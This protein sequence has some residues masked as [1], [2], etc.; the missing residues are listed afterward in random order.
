MASD[1]DST[2]F[3]DTE[4]QS[5]S[6]RSPASET[7]Y[8]DAG[9]A[10]ASEEL[11]EHSA[12]VQS[13]LVSLEEKRKQLER[14]R[15]DVEEAKRRRAE[16]ATGFDEMLHHL[17]RGVTILEE[18][19]IVAKREA[20]QMTKSLAA[21]KNSLTAI[22]QID[23]SKIDQKKWTDSSWMNDVT[24]ALTAVENARHEWN[25][26]RLKWPRLDGVTKEA[27]PDAEG[28]MPAP[29]LGF[30]D[31]SFGQLC[32]LGFALTWPIAAAISA[33]LLVILF[34]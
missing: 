6:H 32:R 8:E 24:K 3:V 26:A 20:E 13:Q 27:R 12:D 21:L 18:E 15:S 23:Q 14:E 10:P 5:T 17:V 29:E 30:S 19:T 16:L 11:S 2:E 1:F 33:L 7:E 31:Q 28:N 4:V 34:R 22:N 9:S 25:A